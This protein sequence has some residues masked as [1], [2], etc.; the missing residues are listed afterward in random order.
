MQYFENINCQTYLGKNNSTTYISMRWVLGSLLQ[1]INIFLTSHI[2][3]FKGKGGGGDEMLQTVITQSTSCV[4]AMSVVVCGSVSLCVSLTRPPLLTVDCK[5]LAAHFRMRIRIRI[6][7]RMTMMRMRMTTF[8]Q[9]SGN[10]LTSFWQI[11]G[12][13]LTTFWQVSGNFWA[14]FW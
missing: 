3:H 4:V 6:R 1:S 2:G 8:W 14:T 12:N 11:S 7:I 9:L 5:M 13:F 10:F